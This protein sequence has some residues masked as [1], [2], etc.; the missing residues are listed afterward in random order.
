MS[1]RASMIARLREPAPFDLLVAGGGITGCGVAYEAA[2]RGARV[3]L[4]EQRDFASGTSSRSTKLIHG[5]IRYLK[6]ADFR[7][8]SEG[9]RE[10]Q[11]LIDQAP[12]LVH[13]VRFVY[14]VHQ[15]D[16]DP[17]W[18]LR[19]G[20]ILYDWF[21]GKRNV[22]PHRIMGGQSLLEEEPLLRP[23]GIRGGAMYA[24]CLTDDARLTMEVA[25]AAAREGAVLLN[26]MEVR[27]FLYDDAGR[28]A[29]VEA[30]DRL[31]G[32][33]PIQLRAR[34]VLNATGPWLDRIREMEEPG[35]PPVLRPTKGAH[36]TVRHQRLP[37]RHPVVMH[38]PDRR[39]MF[40]VPR[41]GFTYL[42]TTD[43][44]YKGDLEDVRPD[45]SDVAYI[46]AAA[47]HTFPSVRLSEADVVSA[48]AGIRPLAAT[49][50]TA[51]PSQVS[52]EYKLHT[53]P[54]GL[55]S[56]AGGKLTAFQSM[57]RAIVRQMLPHLPHY[58]V[59]LKLSCAVPAPTAAEARRIGR[60]LGLGA[61]EILELWSRHGAETLDVLGHVRPAP[62]PERV[63]ML[64][65]EA[66]FA[67]AREFAVTL[68]DILHRRTAQMLF[69]D[70]NGLGAARAA[71]EAAG[72]ILGWDETESEQQ[73][74]AYQ[75]EVDAMMA[76]RRT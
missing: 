62:A 13:P 43:T 71:A 48:W 21:A 35:C 22:L 20:L 73:V 57:A 31:A 4:L 56:V 54:S 41:D 29:G 33:T 5:G 14:P 2:A 70:D 25:K 32:D 26:Y 58:E 51:G 23:E 72:E 45:R 6:H 3:L 42:G 1:T 16:P 64:A 39:M 30:A 15:G 27:R 36:I 19:L 47:G 60:D 52:R 75:A 76:W 8:V 11:N 67:A 65:A 18:A 63:R 10:R 66:A 50:E 49:T 53:S 37:I 12:H 55:V 68:T 24:D 74:D 17:L 61:A 28:V 44:D 9:V 34:A 7:L 38:G 46:L 69:S 59:P 40:A